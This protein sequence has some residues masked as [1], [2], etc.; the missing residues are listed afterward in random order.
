MK[1]WTGKLLRVDLATR[2]ITKEDIPED[3]LMAYVGGRGLNDKYL[4]DEV[5][6]N[7]DPLGPQNKVI[8]GTGPCNGTLVPGNSR[9]TLTT[10]SP[11]TGF[12]GDT[13]SGGSLGVQLKYAGYDMVVIQGQSDKPVYLRIEDDGAQLEDASSIWGKTTQATRR[14]ILRELGNPRA[15]VACIGPAGENKVKFAAVIGDLGNA[16]GRTGAGAVMGAMKL[17]AIVAYGTGGVKVAD[18]DAL[19]KA[20]RKVYKAWTESP[21]FNA[22]ATM[23]GAHKIVNYHVSGFLPTKNYLRGSY[24]DIEC[25]SGSSLLKYLSYGKSCFSCPLPCRHLFF[26]KDGKFSGTYGSGL[27]LGS[28]EH[29][30]SRLLISDLAFA[31][32]GHALCNDLGVDELEMAQAA[33]FLMEAMNSGLLTKSDLDG[34]EIDWGDHARTL[35]LF[36]MIAYRKGIG[37]VFADGIRKAVQVFGEKT[38]PL[39]LEVKGM[40]ISTRDPRGSMAWGLGYAVASRG[41]DHCRSLVTSEGPL[42]PGTVGFDPRKGELRP[43]PAVDALST[44]GKGKMVKW[45]EDMRAFH[46]CMQV[47]AFTTYLHSAVGPMPELMTELFNAVTGASFTPEEAMTIGE[48]VVNLERL[49]NLREGLTRSDDSLPPRFTQEPAPDGPPKGHVVELEPMLDEYYEAR[50]WS[51][52]GVPKTEILKKLGLPATVSRR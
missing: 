13:S 6:S 27:Q 52:E 42:V 33:A 46:N 41:A 39:A 30:S 44:S 3:S 2:R 17:K 34:F 5:P 29:L 37:D 40:T 1:G 22:Y 14:A 26:V 51:K 4:Y 43:G 20:A 21:A 38:K 9:F 16:A 7:I 10:K 32:K 28:L 15:A 24:D 8:L 11:L 35:E 49:F 18:P 48:R 12:L 31:L 36:E 23:T 25:I 45:Y 19:K 50:G 47:C